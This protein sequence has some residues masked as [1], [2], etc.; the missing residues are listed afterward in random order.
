MRA[1][2]GAADD[3]SA[4]SSGEALASVDS[5]EVAELMRE[6]SGSHLVEVGFV[7]I[8]QLCWLTLTAVFLDAYVKHLVC[9]TS[10]CFGS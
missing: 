5:D 7:Q 1:F 6:R 4:P 9:D 8:N 2:L 3:V 10:N